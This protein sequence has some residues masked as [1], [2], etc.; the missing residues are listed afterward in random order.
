MTMTD[1]RSDLDGARFSLTEEQRLSLPGDTVEVDLDFATPKGGEA[2]NWTGICG[3]QVSITGICGQGVDDKLRYV[4]TV[5]GFGT[6]DIAVDASD[7]TVRLLGR[8]S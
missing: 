5:G 4:A 3:V 2:K 6:Y 8:R 7:R 1:T